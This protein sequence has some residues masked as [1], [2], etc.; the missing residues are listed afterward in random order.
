MEE[1]VNKTWVA[2]PEAPTEE[3][4][5]N[6]PSLLKKWYDIQNRLISTVNPALGAGQ[7]LLVG[8]AKALGEGV[9][10]VAKQIPSAIADKA[11]YI[12]TGQTP[13]APV[14]QE[15][16]PPVEEQPMLEKGDVSYAQPQTTQPQV[17]LGD[18]GI[19]QKY[20]A[21][22]KGLA[23]QAKVYEEMMAERKRIADEQLAQ[24]KAMKERIDDFNNKMNKSYEDFAKKNVSIDNYWADKG[25]GGK[26]LAGLAVIIGGI[27]QA[28]GQARNTGLDVINSAIDR[29]LNIQRANIEK[30]KATMEFQ[31]GILADNMKMFGDL[32]QAMIASKM[33]MLQGLDDK[34]KQIGLSATSQ[35][36]VGEMNMARDS[37]QQEKKKLD[38]QMQ[39]LLKKGGG[40]GLEKAKSDVSNY[41]DEI[42]KINSLG[43]GISKENRDKKA[44][45]IALIKA[46]LAKTIL[47]GVSPRSDAFKDVMKSAN[48]SRLF[49]DNRE[50]D[51][52]NKDF[53]NA[54]NLSGGGDDEENIELNEGL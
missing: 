15:I 32:D 39:E 43:A 3:S 21:E 46:N 18:L 30:D 38:I 4:I 41:F 27:G 54:M 47:K 48:V 12:A 8:G 23:D 53:V 19:R 7:N 13:Q 40:A 6:N 50:I 1:T 10:D 34:L 51:Q 14:Q 24:H 29:D 42:K 36:K 16:I 25:T 17:D 20:G 52:M 2:T 26:I 11:K 22:M 31:K 37:L 35:A 9:V 33:T 49:D 44:R 5:N 45:Y 28:Q